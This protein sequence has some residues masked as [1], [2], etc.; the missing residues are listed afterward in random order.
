MSRVGGTNN[1]SIMGVKDTRHGNDNT[2]CIEGGKECKMLI[3]EV[4]SREN[5]LRAH[6]KVV[7]N[8]GGKHPV[9]TVID[10]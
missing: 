2:D 9:K 10:F 4:L 7:S 6:K 1:D 5:L 3:N 8:K